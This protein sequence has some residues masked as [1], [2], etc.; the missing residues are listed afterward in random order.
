V[1]GT[2]LAVLHGRHELGFVDEMTLLGK[3]NEPRILLLGA[4]AWR[5]NHLDW[6]RRIAYVVP[7]DSTGSFRWQGEGQVLHLDL[8]QST[9]CGRCSTTVSLTG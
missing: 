6:Q 3:Q 9:R 7:A 4:R 2:R 5:V 8:C 1:P